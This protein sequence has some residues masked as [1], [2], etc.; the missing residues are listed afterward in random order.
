[1]DPAGGNN[2]V[3]HIHKLDLLQYT[4]ENMFDASS[5]TKYILSPYLT[6]HIKVIRRNH[7]LSKLLIL[8]KSKGLGRAAFAVGEYPFC[9]SDD[10]SDFGLL[11]WSEM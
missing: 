10:S 7:T 3:R 2:K 1:M 9:V 11:F 4:E 5:G 6:E 8:E